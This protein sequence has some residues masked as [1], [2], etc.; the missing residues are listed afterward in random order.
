MRRVIV[1]TAGHIDHGKTKLVEAI[2][3]IDCDRWEE[4]H[5]RGITIDLGFAHLMRG[6]LQIGFIDVPGHERFLHNALAGLGG[7]RVLMLVVAADEG[8]KPQTLEHLEICSLLDIPQAVVAMTK[9]DL[10]ADD[11]LELAR[12]EIEEILA[13]S[14]WPEARILPTSSTTG[15][16]V[17]ELIRHIEVLAGALPEEGNAAGP[18]RLPI[19]RAFQFRGLGSIVTGTLVSGTVTVGDSLQ[20]AP[21]DRLAKVRS[22]QIHGEERQEAVAGERTAIQLSGVSLSELDRGLQLV[23]ADAFA[24]STSLLVE[25]QHLPSAPAPIVGSTPIRLHL[26]SSEVVGRLRPL[27]VERIEPGQAAVAEVKLAAP[28][29]A[30][31]GDRFVVRRPSPPTT[32][33]G[34]PVLDPLWQRRRGARLRVAI[35]GLAGPIEDAIRVW[36][37]DTGLNGL[38]AAELAGRLGVREQAAEQHLESL[39]RSG[40]L[41]TVDSGQGRPTCWMV[42][43][44]FERLAERLQTLLTDYLT[45]ERL[46]NGMPKAEAVRRLLPGVAAE[47][48][49][50]YLERLEESGRLVVRDDLLTL[51]G[52][53]ASLTDE[54][55]GLSRRL[56][57]LYDSAGLTP[58]PPS[59][60]ARLTGAKPQIVEG[61]VHYLIRSGKLTKIGGGLI[62]SSRALERLQ[63]ELHE[64]GLD[65]FTVAQ[66][67]DQFGLTRK[68]AIPILEHLDA[69]RITH[70]SGDIRR[71]AKPRMAT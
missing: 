32:L 70:R 50:V 22:L 28:V 57:E 62:I 46:A 30:T 60:A 44:R 67:R 59:E 52:R 36:V 43:E 5:E 45:R 69:R 39:T 47:L 24:P 16:G 41:A 1:G 7:I 42:P 18:V 23:D 31:R 10:V 56:T 3:G 14:P 35:A 8:I 6:D 15:D 61:V 17:E 19:D 34:G 63:I 20:V 68:W 71:V 11:L 40:A 38:T 66:F 49:R 33:G 2:T 21:G 37:D 9:S 26:F 64:S 13:T 58:P 29:V 55:S 12:M 48:V 4:E 51:P 54:E 27:G 53:E 25:L 65:E